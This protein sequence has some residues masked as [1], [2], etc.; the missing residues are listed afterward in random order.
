[1][2]N[3]CTFEVAGMAGI[4]AGEADITFTDPRAKCASYFALIHNVGTASDVGTMKVYGGEIETKK[5]AILV[6][7]A[8]TEILVQGAKIK[9]EIGVLLK[10]STSLDPNAASA[11][12]PTMKVYGIHAT[13]K[14]MDVEGDILHDDKENRGMTVYL[15]ATT[16]K[17]AIKDASIKIDR[18]SKWTATADSNVTIVSE[19]E[20]SQIDAPAGVTITAIAGQR[21]TYKLASCGTLVLKAS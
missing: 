21:G 17:G 18:L 9:S 4:I 13:F 10:S 6:K 11:A 12:K 5:A 19:V 7:S 3:R 2:L 14:D 20:V 8:N 1:V 15:E 16:L